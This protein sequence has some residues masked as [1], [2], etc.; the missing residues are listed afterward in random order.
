VSLLNKPVRVPLL[1]YVTD[2]R[3]LALAESAETREILLQKI[4]AAVAAGVDWIQIREKDLSGKECSALAREGVRLAA[5]S[6]AGGAVRAR[7]LVNDRLDVALAAQAAGVHLG[8]KSLPP[9]EA[10]RLAN[11]LRREKDFLIGVSCHSL[12]AAKAAEREGA[13]YLFFGPVFATPS[14]AAYGAPQGL[15]RL[16]AVCR[17][18]S[19]PVLAIG[20]I[21][22]ENAAACLSA[23]ASG[24]AAIRLFQDAPEPAFVVRTL[25]KLSP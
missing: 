16:A 12:A 9:Q 4:A 14:K 1:C 5:S 21:T 25:K 6:P 18:V 20:G 8:E 7:I 2:R 22:I 3:S 23:G 13:D 19:L 17:A 24:I 15:E 10:R 11:A